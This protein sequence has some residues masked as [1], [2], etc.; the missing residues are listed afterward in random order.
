MNYLIDTSALVRVMREQVS[1]D[2]MDLIER[3]LVCLCSPVLAEALVTAPAKQYERAERNLTDAHPWVPLPDDASDIMDTMRRELAK[4]SAHQG[5][6]VADYLIA[7]T[8]MKR[9]LTILH[10]DADFETLARLIPMVQQRRISSAPP[11][12]EP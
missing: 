1:D 12:D 8:A 11:S 2:W 4:H 3:G 7:A 5:L 6:S 9:N 10:E